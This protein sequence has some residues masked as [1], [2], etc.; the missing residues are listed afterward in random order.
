MSTTSSFGSCG[1]GTGPVGSRGINQ[2][3]LIDDALFGNSSVEVK[4]TTCAGSPWTSIWIALQEQLHLCVVIIAIL[5][6]SVTLR[7]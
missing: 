6:L 5:G 1:S 2:C 3:V 7:A 4:L